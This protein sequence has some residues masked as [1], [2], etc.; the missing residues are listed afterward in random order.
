MRLLKRGRKLLRVRDK[1]ALATA[2][3]ADRCCDGG[4]PNHV[5]AR[6]CCDPER[7]GWVYM[8]RRDCPGY[9]DWLP[10]FSATEPQTFKVSPAASDAC[11]TT[12]P[13]PEGN[14]RTYADIPGGAFFVPVSDQS[15]IVDSCLVP[16]CLNCPECCGSRTMPQGCGDGSNGEPTRCC[17]CGDNYT[18]T[19]TETERITVN[20]TDYEYPCTVG[21]STGHSQPAGESIVTRTASFRFVCDTTTNTRRVIGAS[22]VD[23]ATTLHLADIVV[24]PDNSCLLVSI[25]RGR[26]VVTPVNYSQTWNELQGG[27]EGCGLTRRE[28]A[29]L[30]PTGLFVGDP[31]ELQSWG[32]N[33]YDVGGVCAGQYERSM[34]ACS[35]EAGGPNGRAC[36]LGIGVVRSS[37]AWSGNQSCNGGAF[38]ET[39]TFKTLGALPVDFTNG[40]GTFFGS[41]NGVQEGEWFYSCRW[42]ITPGDPCQSDPC[43]NQNPVG[44]AK[45]TTSR[46]EVAAPDPSQSMADRLKSILAK[47]S[48]KGCNCG[49]K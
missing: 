25:T 27:Q 22:T 4:C 47:R 44:L 16:E 26:T 46:V 24:Q 39:G 9:R 11:W 40:V 28:V 1:R 35:P 34:E 20:G 13:V 29:I 42:N 30:F 5:L 21:L 31:F 41:W 33:Q 10:S 2:S 14:V 36:Q 12:D 38:E 23:G 18:L 3:C 48:R 37:V 19:I 43:Q 6:W 7:T 8:N 15:F 45:S 17:E 32:V 49:R